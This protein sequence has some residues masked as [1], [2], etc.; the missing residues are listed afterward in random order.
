M[1]ITI[2]KQMMFF[3]VF[4]IVFP[5]TSCKDQCAIDAYISTNKNSQFA[6]MGIESECPFDVVLENE[7][8]RDVQRV[9][10]PAG[11]ARLKLSVKSDKIEVFDLD[12]DSSVVD[13]LASPTGH[14]ERVKEPPPRAG[15]RDHRSIRWEIA[16]IDGSSGSGTVLLTVLMSE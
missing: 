14:F 10:Y 8:D 11:K 16:S 2:R 12:R 15:A 4:S 7:L 1:Y 6:L 13:L 9:S 5:L 3:S